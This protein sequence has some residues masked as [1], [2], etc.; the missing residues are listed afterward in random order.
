MQPAFKMSIG[1]LMGLIAVVAVELALFHSVFVIILIPPVTMAVA[2]LN[3]G[4][5]FVLGR[6][7]LLASRIVGML[8]GGLIALFLM[9][10]YYVTAGPS[11]LGLGVGGRIMQGYLSNLAGAQPDP[12]GGLAVFLGRVA[13]SM[14]VL[15]F[16]VLDLVG[17]VMIWAGGSIEGR[18]REHGRIAPVL[19]QAKSARS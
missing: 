1:T 18:L 14:R 8:M 16:V 11:T 9:V 13:G 5:I 3:L 4:L 2:L 17:L 12:A 19:E 15:E 6:N 7:S 10:A